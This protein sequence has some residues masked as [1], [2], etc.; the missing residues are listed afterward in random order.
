[1]NEIVNNLLV[2]HHLD[3]ELDNCTTIGFRGHRYYLCVRCFTA[4]AATIIT[5]PFHILCPFAYPPLL[6]FL[7]FPDWIAR[8]FDCWRGNNFVR[9]ASGFLL[10]TSYSLNLVE[11]FSLRFRL[12]VWV[13][14]LVVVTLYLVTLRYTWHKNKTSRSK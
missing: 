1:M 10:G 8:R 6:I 14:N 3:G 5:T 7:A 2:S 11:L 13:T 4:I 12:I 9:S